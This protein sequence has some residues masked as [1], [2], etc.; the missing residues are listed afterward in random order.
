MLPATRN[1]TAQRHPHTDITRTTQRVA[2]IN[3][4]VVFI[5]NVI[6][7][8]IQ[9]NAVSQSVLARQIDK[10]VAVQLDALSTE[11]AEKYVVR[12]AACIG[13]I[14]VCI[15]LLLQELV[16]QIRSTNYRLTRT[17]AK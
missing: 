10:S 13:Q 8:T 2:G 14:E 1:S 17:P 5:K 11:I 6:E 9:N 12:L 4:F 15:G 16:I 3:L 7:L